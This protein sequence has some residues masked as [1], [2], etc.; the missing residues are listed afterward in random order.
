MR[1]CVVCCCHGHAKDPH[2]EQ[3]GTHRTLCNFLGMLADE[4]RHAY[5]VQIHR[6]KNLQWVLSGCLVGVL[7][8]ALVGVLVAAT[9]L[10]LHYIF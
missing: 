6:R 5:R 2:H 7:V 1:F 9:V 10:C 3:Y 8:G 4:K